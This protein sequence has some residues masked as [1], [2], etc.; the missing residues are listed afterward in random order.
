MPIVVCVLALIPGI[1]S[2]IFEKFEKLIDSF[3]YSF[4]LL[5]IAVKSEP[6]FHYF[7][8]VF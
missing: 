8:D 5:N 4:A 2:D 6:S 1:T 3:L 7:A